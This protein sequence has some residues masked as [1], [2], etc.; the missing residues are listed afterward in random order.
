MTSASAPVKVAFRASALE[1]GLMLVTQQP[2]L[3]R[4]WY[5]TMPVGHLQDGPRPFTLLNENIRYAR[6]RG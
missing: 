6:E 2:V 5:T 4:F 1:G 3:R